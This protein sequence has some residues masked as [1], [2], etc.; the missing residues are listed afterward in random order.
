MSVSFLDSPH[1]MG[2][3]RGFPLCGE[4]RAEHRRSE[5][6]ARIE[7]AG[8]EVVAAALDMSEDCHITEAAGSVVKIT[9]RAEP[10]G[11]LQD[12]LGVLGVLRDQLAPPSTTEGES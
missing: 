7:K 2:D 6:L 5:L 12:Q 10:W 1:A 8:R 3:C 9:L 4:C 11:R